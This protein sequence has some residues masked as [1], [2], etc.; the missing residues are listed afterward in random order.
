MNLQDWIGRSETVDD[1][2]TATPY[3]ALAATLDWPKTPGKDRPP[4]GTPLPRLWH[5]LYFLPINRQSDIG[6]DGH[7]RRGGFMPPVPLP[8]RMWAGSD[9]A[10]HT[11]LLIGDSLQRTSTIA[12]VKEKSGRTGS[13]IFVKV[14]H[15]IRRNGAA[16]VALTEHHNIVYRAAPQPD[17]VTPAPQATAEESTWERRITPDDVLL[18]RYS[19]LTFNGHRIHYD[20]KYV[21][22]VE[23]YPGLVVHGPLIATLLMDLLRR[24]LPDATVA[25]FEFKALRPTFDIHPFSVHGQPSADG[26]TV[27][28]WGRD[29]EGWLT[30]DA[31]ATLA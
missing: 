29:H 31:T 10:F 25:R 3:A 5:W 26:K 1:I 8:R 22:E 21:T 16:E 24:Q 7:A 2:A 9:F 13:L 6:P 11:P 20:R 27:H 28:L 18:F 12:D 15:E 4:P 14:R 23:G 17:D 19:A 30:M